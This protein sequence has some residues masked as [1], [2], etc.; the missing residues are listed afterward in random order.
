VHDKIDDLKKEITTVDERHQNLNTKFKGIFY[1]N[2]K[3]DQINASNASGSE[4]INKSS[5]SQ[6]FSN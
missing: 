5:T 2:T 1:E 3:S 6:E 4:E